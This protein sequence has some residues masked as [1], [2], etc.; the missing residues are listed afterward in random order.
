[1]ELFVF[2][3]CVDA[4][5][6]HSDQWLQLELSSLM[7]EVASVHKNSYFMYY[8]LC[9]S[10]SL[11]IGDRD[12]GG[13]KDRTMGLQPHLILRVLHRKLFFTIEIFSCLP[14]CPIWFDYLPLPMDRDDFH[15]TLPMDRDDFHPT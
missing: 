9:H 7:S 2:Y 13:R 8:S 10:A 6:F 1:M 4:C 15:P 14:I 3:T 5:A 12:I 11:L